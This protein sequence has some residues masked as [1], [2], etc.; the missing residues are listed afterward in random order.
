[1]NRRQVLGLVGTTSLGLS[2]SGCINGDD[3]SEPTEGNGADTEE[4]DADTGE[5][6]SDTH[7][8][9][10]DSTYT[11][12][13]E[14]WYAN[15]Y[16]PNT[17]PEWI[18]EPTP[19]EWQNEIRHGQAIEMTQYPDVEPTDAHYEAAYELYTE[20]YDAVMDNGWDDFDQAVADGYSQWDDIHWVHK[21]FS[22]NDTNIEP[23]QPESL[24]FF[25]DNDE[26]K[27]A[28]IMYFEDTIDGRGEQVGGPLTVW[29]YHA[30]SDVWCFDEVV[31]HR[32]NE[33]E[34]KDCAEDD[35][36]L[37]RTPEMIHV[38]FLKHPE[39]QFATN[40]RSLPN[41]F[42]DREPKRMS[43]DEFKTH[44]GEAYNQYYTAG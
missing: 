13:S 35:L 18:E 40:M 37:P 4:N 25:D 27:L 17:R 20:T 31:S 43:F 42:F 34:T 10:S 28:G 16:E 19:D 5:N 9:G 24:V 36:Q 41:E 14:G 39:G 1:M 8:N 3:G 2:I 7:E 44:M 29:H 30:S 15:L 22:F 11:R 32:I 6:G 38:W 23:S 12:D 21:D 33:M 26:K